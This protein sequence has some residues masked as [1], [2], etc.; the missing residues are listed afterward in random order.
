M[1]RVAEPQE[2]RA[3]DLLRR[4]RL[5]AG[6]ALE[7]ALVDRG[8]VDHGAGRVDLDTVIPAR[9]TVAEIPAERQPCAAMRAAIG[10]RVH[11]S[12]AVAPQHDALGQSR[13]ADRI[14][15]H[16]PARRH[17]VPEIA[18]PAIEQGLG[19]TRSVMFRHV[20]PPAA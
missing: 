8:Y 18:Q 13:D 19:G 6:L 1:Q 20:R 3:L 7:R 10:E 15:A 2:D 4:I 11:L 12:I 17:R 9:E 5:D 16:L 14:A